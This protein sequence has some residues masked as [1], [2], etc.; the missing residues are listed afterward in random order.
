MAR[1][2]RGRVSYA[3]VV[4][5]LALVFAMTGGAIAAQGVIVKNSRQVAPGSINS[6]DLADGRAVG[7]A[8]I[9]PRALTALKNRLRPGPAGPRGETGATGT[10]GPAGPTFG[11]SAGV[12]PTAPSF[13]VGS[14]TF[15]IPRAGNLLVTANWSD[16]FSE[17]VSPGAT[18][19]Y[20]WGL[21]VDGAP[22]PGSGQHVL[23]PP[24][25]SPRSVP[26]TLSGVIPVTA[27]EATVELS[28][29]TVNGTATD[30]PGGGN[31][32]FTVVLLSS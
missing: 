21:Y 6:R 27:G 20:V 7:L 8:D 23:V 9:K 16:G 1:A 22:V 25:Q 18:C 4:A 5:T 3:N 13:D 30:D 12:N 32:S 28:G 15:D 19:D 24:S 14:E 10:R 11:A 17:C 2:L 29:D 31:P 26:L